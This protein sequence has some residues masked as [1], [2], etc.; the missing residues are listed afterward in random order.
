MF[1]NLLR[2]HIKK[3]QAYASARDEYQGNTGIF[4]DANENAIGSATYEAYNRYPDPQQKLLKQKIATIKKVKP[5]N[6][7]L[8]NGSDEAI[9]LLIRA[10]CE[11]QEDAIAILPPTY[12]MYEV[13]A[14]I[15]AV[16]V[17]QI[18]LTQLFQID[19][20]K[21]KTYFDK[22]KIIF[23]CSPNNPTG[24]TIAEP[25]IL[26][27]LEHFEGIVLLDEAYVDFCADKSWLSRLD[28]YPRLVII[29]TFSKAWGMAALRLG[30]AF[31]HTELIAILNKIKSPYNINI[32]T[33]NLALEA[34][35][36]EAKMQEM[37]KV[38]IQQ[39]ELLKEKLKEIAYI[40]DVYPSEANFLLVKMKNPQEVFAYLL[41]KKIITRDRSKVAERAIR[42]SIGTETENIALLQALRDYD[43]SLHHNKK[44]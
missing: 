34:L 38:T 6:I 9:D 15:N 17:Y 42:I 14:T 44:V 13:S 23:I 39:R 26:Y 41:S 33:Q 10:F 27:I 35:D 30:M 2:P 37:V 18:P 3:L 19:L 4:L 28:K 22:V 8:G 21:L 5:E 7:F 32:L 25:D 31:A 40:E 24:N 12:G 20:E 36:N 11:A 43:N 1:D 16:K 29:Q